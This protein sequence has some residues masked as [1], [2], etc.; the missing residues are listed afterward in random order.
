M[1][2]CDA[3]SPCREARRLRPLCMQCVELHPRVGF[4]TLSPTPDMLINDA[5]YVDTFERG[6]ILEDP[7]ALCPYR[8]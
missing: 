5:A 1:I 4:A 8:R 2:G 6:V 3:V 7:R